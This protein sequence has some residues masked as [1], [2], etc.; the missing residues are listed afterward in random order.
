MAKEKS[1]RLFRGTILG[2]EAGGL[3]SLPSIISMLSML[4][5]FSMFSMFFF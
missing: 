4:S 3:G 5:M 1:E 2:R